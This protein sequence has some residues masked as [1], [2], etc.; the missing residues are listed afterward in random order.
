MKDDVKLLK[1]EFERIRKKGLIKSLRSG[2]TGVGY[3]FETLLKKVEDQ[4]CKPDFKSIELKCK[5]GYSKSALTLFN[6]VPMRSGDS[7]IKYIYKNYNHYRF[8]NKNDYKLFA[9]KICSNFSI[10]KAALEF[11]LVVDYYHSEIVMKAYKNGE[12]YEDVCFWDFR[13]LERKLK[14]KLS[15]MALVKAYPY[16]RS[17][18]IYY[19][20]VK[21]DLYKL[22]GFFEFLK[23]IEEDKIYIDFYIKGALG[24]EDDESIIKDHG[25][26]FRIP[27]QYIEELFYKI[28]Y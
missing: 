19:K 20:Y 2:P 5:L 28:K 9:R 3:T 12:Y 23:L 15:Y 16:N 26:A 1:N 6:C 8:G 7:A 27:N 4:E 18:Q 10:N 13:I 17:G 11:K 22:M 14:K 25:V 24:E 21:M